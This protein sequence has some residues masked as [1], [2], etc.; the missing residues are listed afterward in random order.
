MLTASDIVARLE[1]TRAA[2]QAVAAQ[3]EAIERACNVVVE[4]LGGGGTLY[5]AGN[6]GSAAEA[7]HLTEELIGR[8]RG[9]RAPQRA[10]CLNAD[11]TAMTCIANDFGY[12]AV[13]SRQCEA[14]LTERDL[15]VV[16]STSGRSANIMKALEAA[17]ANGAFTLGLL[18]GDGGD[19]LAA[20]KHAIVIPGGDSAHVQEAHLVVVHLLCEAVER[21]LAGPPASPWPS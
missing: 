2:V 3:A 1:G 14:L 10:V 8:Y 6:G 7:M 20:C 12:E 17:A 16:L 19:C 9:D 13:F 4:R 11:P 5:A 21:H 18:G 15:L